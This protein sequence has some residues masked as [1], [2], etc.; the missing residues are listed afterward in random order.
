MSNDIKRIKLDPRAF[1]AALPT[2]V[3]G[4]E[5]CGDRIISVYLTDIFN[6]AGIEAE[7]QYY[8]LSWYV[9]VKEDRC[10]VDYDTTYDPE[11]SFLRSILNFS[12]ELNS[13]SGFDAWYSYKN[14]THCLNLREKEP[15]LN[16]G[17]KEH[18]ESLSDLFN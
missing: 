4:E 16:P 11:E 5:L 12:L 1:I 7:A 9:A 8:D 10:Y 17:E 15:C 6:E 3:E 2:P 13:R 14:N 18:L